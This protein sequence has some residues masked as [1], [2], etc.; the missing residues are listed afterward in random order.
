MAYKNLEKYK[1]TTKRYNLKNKDKISLSKKIRYNKNKDKIKI[2]EKI[3]REKNKDKIKITK[4]IYNEKNKNKIKANKKEYDKKHTK[5]HRKR[6]RKRRALKVSICE[7]Y[8][9]QDELYTRALFHN[10]CFNCG[11]TETLCI[12]HVYP[13]SSGCAL[14]KTNACLLCRTCNSSKSDRDPKNFYTPEKL[15]LLLSILNNQSSVLGGL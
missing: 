7:H 13:L 8:T 15:K 6:S 14:S 10:A 12:D 2:T 4:K 1:L 11:S 9:V 3:Y 5:E